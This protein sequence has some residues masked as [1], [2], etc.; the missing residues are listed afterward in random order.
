MNPNSLVPII[1]AEMVAYREARRRENAPAA[2]R[3][4]ERAHILSQA[5]LRPHLRVHANMFGYAV[6]QRDLREATGQ[7]VRLLLAPLGALTG[8][9]PWGNTGRANVNAFLPMPLPEDLRDQVEA[10]RF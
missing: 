10:S 6:N 3:A 2:W 4:L 5:R 1:E 8:R 7:L 9:L